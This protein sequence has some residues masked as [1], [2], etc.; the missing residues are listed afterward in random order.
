[1]SRPMHSLTQL[2]PKEDDVSI[3]ALSHTPPQ[4]Q[5]M[6]ALAGFSSEKPRKARRGS[7]NVLSTVGRPSKHP[8]GDI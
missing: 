3:Q 4:T 6:G 5:D 1:M 7:K 2:E 8:N